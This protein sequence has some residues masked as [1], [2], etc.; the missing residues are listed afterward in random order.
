MTNS[1]PFLASWGLWTI[2]AGQ[3]RPRGP[4]R[5]RRAQRA[6]P[7]RFPQ[8]GGRDQLVVQAIPPQLK[9]CESNERAYISADLAQLLSSDSGAQNRGGSGALDALFLIKGLG[10]TRLNPFNTLTAPSKLS[11]LVVTG[12][13]SPT[14]NSALRC[15]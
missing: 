7:F 4:L 5:T 15:W 11:H 3:H 1:R 9:A 12:R 13:W 14:S 8:H 2:Y 6:K 10:K